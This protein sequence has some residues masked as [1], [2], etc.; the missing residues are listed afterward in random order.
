MSSLCR[1]LFKLSDVIS[2]GVFGVSMLGV[3]LAFIA[4]PV[5]LVVS[6][7]IYSLN[8]GHFGALFALCFLLFTY[9]TYKHIVFSLLGHFILIVLLFIFSIGIPYFYTVLF[10]IYLMPYV[11]VYQVAKNT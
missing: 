7:I 9:L 3:L 5:T 1:N 11:V 2:G 8:L 6:S 4:P 10:F